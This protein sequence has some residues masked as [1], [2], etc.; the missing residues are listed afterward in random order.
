[1]EPNRNEGRTSVKTLAV[2]LC[3]VI[4]AATLITIATSPSSGTCCGGTTTIE[5]EPTIIPGVDPPPP[6][7]IIEVLDDLYSGEILPSPEEII[8][9]QQAACQCNP[10]ASGILTNIEWGHQR[11]DGIATVTTDAPGNFTFLTALAGPCKAKF[12]QGS[13]VWVG[14]TP[15][16]TGGCSTFS[17]AQFTAPP[18]AKPGDE[19]TVKVSLLGT[20]VPGQGQQTNCAG[21]SVGG[22]ESIKVFISSLD[23]DSDNNGV[24][25]PKVDDAKDQVAPGKV[26][27]LNDNDDNQNGKPDLQDAGFADNDLAEAALTFPALSQINRNIQIPVDMPQPCFTNVINVNPYIRLTIKSGGIRVWKDRNKS[28]LYLPDLRPGHQ[29][30]FREFP[31][32]SAPR[33]VFVEGVQSGQAQLEMLIFPDS[34]TD[35]VLFTVIK[36][37]LQVAN[38]PEEPLM[39]PNT[40]NPPNELDPGAFLC[41]NDD[42]DEQNR[43]IVQPGAL[44]G[45][46]AADNDPSVPASIKQDDDELVVASL[47][48]SPALEGYWKI[49]SANGAVKVWWKDRSGQYVDL[50]DPSNPVTIP[51]IG[52]E[53][54]PLLV[55]GI[56]TTS[57][58]SADMLTATFVPAIAPNV[59]CDDKAKVSVRKSAVEFLDNS[60][61]VID[62]VTKALNVSNYVTT[63]GLLIGN[64]FGDRQEDPDN[65][66]LQ[67]LDPGQ[68]AGSVNVEV[69]QTRPGQA[70]VINFHSIPLGRK[71]GGYFRSDFLR[72]VSDA[73]D[74][75][76]SPNV[77]LV[78]LGDRLTA[79]YKDSRGLACTRTITVGRPVVEEDDGMDQLKH[80]IRETKVRITVFQNAN[81]TGP[82]LSKQEVLDDIQSVNERLAQATIRLKLIGEINMGTDGNGVPLVGK[83]AVLRD[84]FLVGGAAI[85][86]PWE[87]AV[88]ELLDSEDNDTVDIFY[89]N[90]F[91]DN[92]V[93]C[94]SGRIATRHA[95]SYAVGGNKT[96]DEQNQNFIV[97]AA[98]RG[99]LTL[100]HEFMHILLNIPHRKGGSSDPCASEDPETALFHAP[101]SRDKSVGGTKRIGPYPDARAVNVGTKDTFHMRNKAEKLP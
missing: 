34:S 48:A 57:I 90:V 67:V 29:A 18:T 93:V 43:K 63:N 77:I 25:E 59:N 98:T 92:Q 58:S 69:T 86:N 84:G 3:A 71:S 45:I 30:N 49:S 79:K 27:C 17:T 22:E 2:L 16:I 51:A 65:F 97:I 73:A 56:R 62:P 28:E 88:T 31:I 80:D 94:D 10:T 50:T 87:L 95:N 8:A 44:A 74:A 64:D 53:V 41:I 19:F 11:F 40:G 38:L 52:G 78:Q 85:L 101:Q 6:D 83:Q 91:Q 15:G 75:S 96:G 72:L 70:S 23:T 14:A 61:L 5:P 20:A 33:T 9:Q 100:P 26:I 46:P 55:E 35:T 42:F 54:I 60:N 13:P 68:T 36:P 82:V 12:E 32:A 81:G 76:S 99:P 37:D 89:V 1:M 39:T 4:M 66:R 24:V 7:P 21:Q 47:T